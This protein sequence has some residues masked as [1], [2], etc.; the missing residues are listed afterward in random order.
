MRQTVIRQRQLFEQAPTVP[1][2]HLPV[3]VQEQL[4]DALVLWLRALAKTRNQEHG[5]EQ[6]HR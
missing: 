3:E 4:K 6:D 5:D 2:V 1:V